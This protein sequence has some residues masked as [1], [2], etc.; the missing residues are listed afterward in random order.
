MGNVICP[1]Q[2]DHDDKYFEM[3]EFDSASI[4]VRTISLTYLLRILICFY[5]RPLSAIANIRL[6]TEERRRWSFR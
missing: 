2:K 1:E 3:K 4:N 5:G 6:V